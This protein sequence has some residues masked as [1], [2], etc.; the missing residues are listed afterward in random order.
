MAQIREIKCPHCGEWTMWQ[1]NVDDRCLN[2][3]QFIEPN[4]FS[5]EVERRV[6]KQLLKEDG[7]FFVKPT[8]SE[9]KREVKGFFKGLSWVV[10]SLQVLFFIFVTAIIVIISI[11]PG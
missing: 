10:I 9:L 11:L 5:R 3:D 1:G 2:C 8:D 6:N 7:Y 4:R